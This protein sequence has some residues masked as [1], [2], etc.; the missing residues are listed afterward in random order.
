MAAVIAIMYHDHGSDEGYATLALELPEHLLPP[1]RAF[2]DVY[3]GER[4]PMCLTPM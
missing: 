2:G 1:P 4:M 3:C